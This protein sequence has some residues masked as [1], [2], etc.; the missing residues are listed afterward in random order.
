M[1]IRKKQ[2]KNHH[3]KV[4]TMAPSSEESVQSLR[5]WVR[6]IEQSTNSVSSRLTAVETRLSGGYASS[7]EAL[8]SVM[9]GPI[10][11]FF[12]GIQKGKKKTLD[13]RARILDHELH[14]LH[15]EL[16][17]QQQE[18]QSLKEQ[19]DELHQWMP[20]VQRDLHEVHTTVTPMLQQLEIK[21]QMLAQRKPMMMKLGAMEIPV[22]ITGVIGGLLAFTI[23]ILVALNQKAVLLSPVFLAAV[24][25]LLIGSAL[26]KALRMRSRSTPAK[27]SKEDRE[28]SASR[29]ISV[30]HASENG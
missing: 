25:V 4:N 26:V 6:K 13:E 12:S 20:S 17:K 18:Y 2:E 21:T 9:E 22:E 23:A 1:F 16:G 5:S 14:C 24:G 10:E 29:S 27:T 11:R 30:P 8:M 19:V 7:D 15:S 28:S 3:K